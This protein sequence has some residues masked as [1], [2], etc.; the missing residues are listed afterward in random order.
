MSILFEGFF[1]QASLILALGAQNLFVLESGLKRQRHLFVAGLCSI[2]DAALI[3]VGVL[4]VAT[5]LVKIPLLKIS[6]G[7]LGVLFLAWYGGVKLFEK[8]VLQDANSSTIPPNL[9]RIILQTLAFSILNPHVYLDAIVL[10]GGYSTTYD[11]MFERALFGAGATLF[12]VIW[13]LGLALLSAQASRFLNN[14]KSMRIVFV[15]SGCILIA[16]ACKLGVD[17]WQWA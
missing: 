10:I 14:P 3:A 6:L 4:G 15:L 2:C 12:S 16:L 17:V 13:F 9:K 1:L 7:I 8:P 5:V 11:T